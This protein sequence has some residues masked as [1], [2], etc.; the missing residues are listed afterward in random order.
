MQ[1]SQTVIGRKHDIRW[2]RVVLAALLTEVAVIGIIGIAIVAHRLWIAPGETQAQSRAFGEIA[3]YYA[4]PAGGAVMTFLF[5]LWVCR[6]LRSHFVLHG[7]LV[8]LAGVLL[9]VGFI[10]TAKPEYSFMYAASYALRIAAGYGGGLVARARSQTRDHSRMC[11]RNTAMAPNRMLPE[12]G[13]MRISHDQR[14]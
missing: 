7:L 3:G 12:T 4:G 11:P 2:G 14:H 1:P 13:G 8:G 9:T 5:V 6:P 10:F